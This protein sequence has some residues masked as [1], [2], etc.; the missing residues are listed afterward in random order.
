MWLLKASIEDKPLELFL[1]VRGPST[2]FRKCDTE[3]EAQ[4]Y[5]AKLREMFVVNNEEICEAQAKG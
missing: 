4:S 1:T 5:L 3:Q 2:V